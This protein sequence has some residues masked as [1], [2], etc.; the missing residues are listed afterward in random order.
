MKTQK[1]TETKFVRV[2][3]V[4]EGEE[5]IQTVYK[6]IVTKHLLP[7]NWIG[8]TCFNYINI[9]SFNNIITI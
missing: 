8:L 2:D 3:S 7:D 1:S 5:K 9:L 4:K 6:Y